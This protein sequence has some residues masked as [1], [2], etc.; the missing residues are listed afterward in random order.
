MDP[1][2]RVADLLR[3]AVVVATK[4]K[5]DAFRI[6]AAKEL[7]G[8]GEE[9]VP[10]YRYLQGQLKAH[11][12]Y[13]GWTPVIIEDSE[14]AEKLSH[15]GAGQSIGELEDLY[16][17][18]PEAG[19]T[20][21]VP[22]PH[23]WLLQVFGN[24]EAFRLGMIPTLLIDRTA[25]Y[26]VLD[27][28][29]NEVLQWS[30]QLEREGILGAGMSFSKE[31]VTRAATITY[32]ISQFTGVL[33]DVS[34]SQMQFGDFNRIYSELKRLGISQE[35]RNDLENILD[36]VQT[37]TGDRRSSLVRR[38]MEWVTRNSPA[39][40]TLSETIRGWFDTLS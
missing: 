20:L 1:S 22:L 2:V 38:G 28:V 21:Q 4:L 16:T 26:G 24:T 6:W 12:P 29:R 5:I 18:G 10:P 33:G 9:D 3:K 7:G 14:L 40:G 36:E 32:N 30:L 37:A 34:S 35:E 23:K 19:S 8:Y 13:H 31:E 17:R 27:T 11:N 15:R 39:I 25:I